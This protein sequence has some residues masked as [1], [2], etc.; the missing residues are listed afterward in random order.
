LLG[1]YRVSAGGDR[2]VQQRFA[3]DHSCTK[4]FTSLYTLVS[5]GMGDER[6]TEHVPTIYLN[7]NA[8]N[9]MTLA[10]SSIGIARD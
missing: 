1:R 8:A 5:C 4:R 10:R 2:S 7:P 6:T 3:Y 9:T